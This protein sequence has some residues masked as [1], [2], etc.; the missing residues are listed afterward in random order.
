ME[1]LILLRRTGRIDMIRYELENLSKKIRKD[2]LIMGY[3]SGTKGAHIGGGMSIV[4]ILAV[5]YGEIMKYDINN[6]ND[7]LRDRFI[8]SKAHSG[9]GL[10]AALHQVGLIS[11][12]E[13]ENAFI[14]GS[15]FYKHPRMDI[16]HGIEF[17]GGSLGQ[18]LS[19]AVG[20][21]LALRLKNN[22]AK[23]YVILGDGECDEGSI[24]EACNSIVHFNLNNVVTIVDRNN[25]QNDGPTEKIMKLSDIGKRFES[26][27]F[28]VIDVNGHDVTELEKA[29][30]QE[31]D[32]PKVI[33][34][35]TIK[36]KGVSFA[37]NNV[38]WHIG[39]LTKELYEKA[40]REL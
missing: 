31:T 33:I 6:P 20:S 39:Y 26:M 4:E 12:K 9:I 14:P 40:M 16:K 30:G 15:P 11:D 19:L 8:L 2:I 32:K 24:W 17:T 27:G 25:L 35:H 7:D 34:A 21:A 5:L 1:E 22:P 18:G 38:D 13:F 36:G 10:Y 29:F 23:I 28:F 3:H 37:E